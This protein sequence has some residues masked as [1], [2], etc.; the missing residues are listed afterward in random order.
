VWAPR[1]QLSRALTFKIVN[2]KIVEVEITGDPKRL[3][4][5][6]LAVL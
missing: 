6:D 3:G 1:G 5:L 2:G 4:Q